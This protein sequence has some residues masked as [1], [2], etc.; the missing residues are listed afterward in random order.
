MK[1]RQDPIFS[2]GECGHN[3]EDTEG[4]YCNLLNGWGNY[5]KS[6]LIKNPEKIKGNCPILHYAWYGLVHFLEGEEL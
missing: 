4:G 3:F 6:C 5:Q 2:C 1:D